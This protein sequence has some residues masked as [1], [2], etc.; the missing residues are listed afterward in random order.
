MRDDKHQE[1]FE[2]EPRMA[3]ALSLEC[4]QD[5]MQGREIQTEFTFYWSTAPTELWAGHS[6]PLQTV[7]ST[8]FQKAGGVSE[9]L[10]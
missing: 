10:A 6:E 9:S 2:T 1:T 8:S 7:R 4:V 5:L 3:S